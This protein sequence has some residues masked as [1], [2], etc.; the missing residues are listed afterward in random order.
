M[1]NV[2]VLKNVLKVSFSSQANGGRDWQT[3]CNRYDNISY[4]SL[5]PTSGMHNVLSELA[6]N[7]KPF[8]R[9]F[10]QKSS[11]SHQED[12]FDAL[13]L[14]NLPPP[15]R[16]HDGEISIILWWVWGDNGH[17]LINYPRHFIP[18]YFLI[19]LW[20]QDGNYIL[21]C[22]KKWSDRQYV[23]HFIFSPYSSGVE[24]RQ[25]QWSPVMAICIIIPQSYVSIVNFYGGKISITFY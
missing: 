20:W 15:P 9:L 1:S 6:T 10:F 8:D 14:F 5:L 7:R 12:P 4:I 3:V 25:R 2:F 13:F 18:T 16:K 24:F 17:H 11:N 21:F 23:I 19:A 22:S